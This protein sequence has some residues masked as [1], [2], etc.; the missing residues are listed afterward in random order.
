MKRRFL[1]WKYIGRQPYSEGILSRAVHGVIFSFALSFLDFTTFLQQIFVLEM[2]V[3]HYRKILVSFYTKD[4][5]H[6]ISL[7]FQTEKDASHILM[8][9][10]FL[11]N[12]LFYSSVSNSTLCKISLTIPASSIRLIPKHFLPASFK[13]APT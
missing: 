5:C 9:H 2:M 8:T 10:A 13:D 11:H 4:L 3:A 12:L 7:P 6:S 1:S